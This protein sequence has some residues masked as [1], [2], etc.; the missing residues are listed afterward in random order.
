MDLLKGVA[1]EE[2]PVDMHYQR[3][4]EKAKKVCCVS[5][6]GG[7]WKN[8]RYVQAGGSEHETPANGATKAE[9]AQHFSRAEPN[10]RN[11]D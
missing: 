8:L 5:N 3:L 7:P 9:R 2:H 1:Y 4:Y 11:S 6:A 10:Q